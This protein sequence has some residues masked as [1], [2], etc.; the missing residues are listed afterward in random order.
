MISAF[1]PSGG[2][3]LV[4]FY[5]YDC[6]SDLRPRIEAGQEKPVEKSGGFESPLRGGD[7]NNLFPIGHLFAQREQIELPVTGITGRSSD[8]E[9]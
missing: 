1:L 8:G 2:E 3:R 7:P 9:G 6:L 4:C 5:L